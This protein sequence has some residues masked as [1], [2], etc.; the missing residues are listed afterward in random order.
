M[1]NAPVKLNDPVTGRKQLARVSRARIIARIIIHS[2]NP[3]NRLDRPLCFDEKF[4]K[5]N[6]L[7][8]SMMN[9]CFEQE[10]N[11]RKQF[12]ISVRR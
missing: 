10:K 9:C 2:S 11:F 7:I 12:F 1:A 5:K 3:E 4:C 8:T 6:L